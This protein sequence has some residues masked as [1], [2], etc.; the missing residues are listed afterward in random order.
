MEEEGK[1]VNISQ[2]STYFRLY[3]QMPCAIVP[4]GLPVCHTVYCPPPLSLRLPAMPKHTAPEK[5]GMLS[6]CCFSK[7]DMLKAK[8]SL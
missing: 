1:G 6:N 5:L 2:L 8:P 4:S 3:S 7:K